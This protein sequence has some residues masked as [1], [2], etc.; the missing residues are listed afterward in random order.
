MSGSSY[1]NHPYQPPDQYGASSS[2]YYQHPQESQQPMHSPQGYHGN[3]DLGSPNSQNQYNQPPP[4]ILNNTGMQAVSLVYPP[5]ALVPIQPVVTEENDVMGYR[6]GPVLLPAEV[7]MSIMHMTVPNQPPPSAINQQNISMGQLHQTDAI[8]GEDSDR[9]SDSSFRFSER[10]YL[11][12]LNKFPLG[13]KIVEENDELRNLLSG[14]AR[15]MVQMKKQLIVMEG[16]LESLCL[17]KT[18]QSTQTQHV[19]KESSNGKPSD[20]APGSL[21]L[22][23]RENINKDLGDGETQTIEIKKGEAPKSSEAAPRV[24]QI[25]TESNK[26]DGNTDIPKE[27]ASEESAARKM[28]TEHASTVEI[29]KVTSSDDVTPTAPPKHGNFTKAEYA[30]VVQTAA[31]SSQPI[32]Y[33]ATK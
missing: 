7:V 30:H 10:I 8:H 21:D 28:I 19:E 33:I 27:F 25:T 23:D 6:I 16:R 26:L 15:D 4:P 17:S 29:V 31:A 32:T 1:N 24:Q 12:E 2:G 3:Y 5:P 13:R 22:T 14:M 18:D 20:Q 9:D 11:E